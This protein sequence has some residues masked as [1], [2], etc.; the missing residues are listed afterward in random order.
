MPPSDPEFY[1]SF[2]L[3]N[4]S[5]FPESEKKGNIM[6]ITGIASGAKAPETL[7]L[8]KNNPEDNSLQKKI[9]AKQK[10]LEQLS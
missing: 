10:E 3:G 8:R 1:I 5:G 4:P 7:S 2:F 6:Q 9:E